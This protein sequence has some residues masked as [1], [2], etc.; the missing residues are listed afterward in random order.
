AFCA[1]EIAETLQ[2]LG[3]AFDRIDPRIRRRALAEVDRRV[4]A[5]F[6]ARSDWWWLW[7]QPGRSQLNNWTAVCSGS[8]LCAALAALITDPIRQARIAHKAAWSLGFFQDTFGAAGSLD[9]GV[10]YWSYGFSHYVMAAER[11]A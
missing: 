4:F 3:A 9:E 7:K 10:G 2:L 1:Q 11:L 8:V 6:L 5:P